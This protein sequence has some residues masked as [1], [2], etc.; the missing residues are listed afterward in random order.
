MLV[1]SPGHSAGELAIAETACEGTVNSMPGPGS[2][3]VIEAL[4]VY[5]KALAEGLPPA[6]AKI[7][8]IEAGKRAA[9]SVLCYFCQNSADSICSRCG[10]A[11]Y[12]KHCIARY[13]T[14]CRH[15]GCSICGQSLNLICFECKAVHPCSSVHEP[16]SCKFLCPL[17]AKATILS[18]PASAC[19][20]RSAS[21]FGHPAPLIE[22][23]VEHSI[24]HALGTAE[25]AC[26]VCGKSD[27]LA[28]SCSCAGATRWV[29]N[30]CLMGANGGQGVHSRCAA[31]SRVTAGSLRTAV[32]QEDWRR[33]KDTSDDRAV[34]SSLRELAAAHY[35]K[36]R[37][38]PS[39]AM[40]Q[41]EQMLA[42]E[43]RK[44]SQLSNPA[45]QHPPAT[46]NENPTAQ[47]E[48]K[49]QRAIEQDEQVLA[50]GHEF[51]GK[52][53]ELG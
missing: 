33:A 31:C 40:Q 49:L 28:R 24:E 47:I 23:S 35:T 6:A 27:K 41:Y 48:A 51:D 8:A 9:S 2:Q 18:P 42:N 45:L 1:I 13:D 21:P 53:P 17:A 3:S 36:D 5:R 30:T 7:A 46:D 32:A 29:H 12:C 4:E 37:K 26:V 16:S 15:L 25:L 19:S 14:P 52:L 38:G 22:H 50:T 11:H 39:R 44:V 34:W 10:S 20:S 43:I